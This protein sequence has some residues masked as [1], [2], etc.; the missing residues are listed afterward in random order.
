MEKKKKKVKSILLYSIDNFLK[1]LYSLKKIKPKLQGG[2]YVQNK[3]KKC[4]IFRRWHDENS[5][6]FSYIILKEVPGLSNYLGINTF[7]FN[8]S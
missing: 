2:L 5:I 6:A 7:E 8:H 3:N 4:I 1:Y